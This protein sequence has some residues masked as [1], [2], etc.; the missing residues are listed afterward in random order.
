MYRIKAL[1]PIL[2]ALVLIFPIGADAATGLA[3][4]E[5]GVDAR[6]TLFGEAMTSHVADGSAC[7]WTPAGLASITAA[8]LLV[9]HVESFAY[10]KHCSHT[11]LISLK[12]K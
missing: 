12:K 2:L 1:T 6:A 7:Y 4:L 8:Q 5:N 3:F 9:T 10:K 11:I